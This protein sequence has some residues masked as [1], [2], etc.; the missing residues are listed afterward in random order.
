MTPPSALGDRPTRV[1]LAVV[2]LRHPTIRAVGRHVGISPMSALHDL[3]RLR[4]AG[5]VDWEP[6][7]SGAGT[8]RPLVQVVAHG[9]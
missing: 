1:L 5:L 3:R 8:L 2:E 4:D 7:P 6:G 9:Q